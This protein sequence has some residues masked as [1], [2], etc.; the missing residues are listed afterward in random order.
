MPE[1]VLLRLEVTEV[2]PKSESDLSTD[3]NKSKSLTSSNT[4]SGI[5]II[6]AESDDLELDD[7]VKNNEEN[8]N[9]GNLEDTDESPAGLVKEATKKVAKSAISVASTTATIGSAAYSIYSNY[10]QTGL[11]LSGATHAAAVQARKGQ[12]ANE[13]VG[14][15]V[16]V[17]INPA[18]AAPMIAMKAWQLSQT[19]RRELFEMKKS[20][21][22]STILQRN[23]VK[24]VAERRF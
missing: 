20:Q 18:L 6:V 21:M 12:A 3:S 15:G 22:T 2:K 10:Q 11:E 24:N 7:I 17:M 19:N 5:G 9:G 13:L 16:A 14:L 4:A 8:S 23:L 1:V